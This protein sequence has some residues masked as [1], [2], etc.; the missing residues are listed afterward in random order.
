MIILKYFPEIFFCSFD[1]NICVPAYPSVPNYISTTPIFLPIFLYGADT[2][3]VTV[4]AA[5]HLTFLIIGVYA[6]S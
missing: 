5:K 6:E 2:W 4:I 3:A 1:H